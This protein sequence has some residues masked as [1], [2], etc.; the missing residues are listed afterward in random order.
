MLL[1]QLAVRAC[2]YKVRLL[3]KQLFSIHKLLSLTYRDIVPSK[4][5]LCVTC[6]CV[7]SWTYAKVH[8]KAH[9]WLC[10]DKRSCDRSESLGL[11]TCKLL[12]LGSCTDHALWQLNPRHAQ[13]ASWFAFLQGQCAHLGIYPRQTASKGSSHL[14][15]LHEQQLADMQQTCMHAVIWSCCAA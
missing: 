9:Y 2:C 4:P 8:A 6:V 14:H 13:Y 12:S 11:Q 3:L 7:Q 5:C 15:S 10:G 1:S